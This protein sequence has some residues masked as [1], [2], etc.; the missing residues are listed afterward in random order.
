[1]QKRGLLRFDSNEKW[2]WAL[3][4]NS[5]T[6]YFSFSKSL[7]SEGRKRL[8][9]Y[10]SFIELITK[11][12]FAIDFTDLW[13]S[14]ISIN[15]IFFFI[16]YLWRNKGIEKEL[17]KLRIKSWTLSHF[18]LIFKGYRSSQILKFVHIFRIVRVLHW[19]Y[20]I[21]MTV[22]MVNVD[23]K[24]VFKDSLSFYKPWKEILYVREPFLEF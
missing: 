14:N 5:C 22:Y 6:L 16:W 10:F 15:E 23:F 3:K 17:R 7:N 19:I 18:F 8:T 2:S 12:L 4:D 20:S 13:W 9:F 21:N 24:F 11:S 1:M